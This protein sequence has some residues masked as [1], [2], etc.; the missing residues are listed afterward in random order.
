MSLNTN[1]NV[2]VI[3]S[4]PVGIALAC[5]LQALNRKAR[6]CVID[7]RADTT[8]NHGLHID[9]DSVAKL[10]E[11]FTKNLLTEDPLVDKPAV[12]QLKELFKGW[13]GDV[14]RTNTIETTL[15]ETA[16]RLAIDV[17]RGKEY[18][19]TEN[20]F[21]ALFAA[22]GA[23][24]SLSPH[25]QNLR[26]ILQGAKVVIGA[27]GSHSV[28]RKKIMG[29]ELVGEEVLQHLIELKFQTDG[30]IPKR[31]IFAKSVQS[32]KCAS[33]DF[34]TIGR[35]RKR[36]DLKPVTLHVV[37]DSQTFASLRKQDG[38]DTVLKGDF[39]HP[40]NLEELKE[41]A[42]TNDKIKHVFERFSLY[43]AD[44]RKRGGRCENAKIT[45]IPM[46]VYRSKETVKKYNN[47]IVALAGDANS[48]TIF[49]R[50]FNKGLQEAALCADAVG[51]Y[52][53]RIES[54]DEAIGDVLPAEL[55]NYQSQAQKLFETEVQS[56]KLKNFAITSVQFS[57]SNLITPI[58]QGILKVVDWVTTFFSDLFM[59]CR[60]VLGWG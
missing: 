5:T 39:E 44:I 55:Q 26:G 38:N 3:G 22:N 12:A 6:I 43:L 40:W 2:V 27:D 7:K 37:V 46:R 41:L 30:D 28:I 21:D 48:G 9:S 13:R 32:A 54:K 31:D 25:Q 1:Y 47:T 42:K 4:G 36:S 19:I 60:S 59:K 58:F 29:N 33:V 18:A 49:A 52:L 17:F 24:D 51:N 53:K 35:K 8:R 20:S 56:A 57:L 34:E 23:N 14:V 16:K 10:N 45:G 50:G 15:E 11:I